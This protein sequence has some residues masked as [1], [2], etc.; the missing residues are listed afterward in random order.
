MDKSEQQGSD[1]S[2]FKEAREVISRNYGCWDEHRFMETYADISRAI[3]D[4]R[5]NN[6]E[7]GYVKALTDPKYRWATAICIILALANQ[8]TGIN[9]I[10]IYATTIYQNL[11]EES[12]SGGGISPRVGTVLNGAAQMVAIL[13]T[14]FVTNFSFRLIMNGGFFLMAILMTVVGV[15]ALED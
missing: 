2:A 9:A 13:L 11:Q 14:P 8:I 12:E 1:S 10:N 6:G 7:I 15:L 3:N 5:S 4:N